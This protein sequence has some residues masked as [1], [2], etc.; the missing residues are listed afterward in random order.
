MV[1]ESTF[2]MGQISP[3]CRPRRLLAALPFGCRAWEVLAI[4]GLLAAERV[5]PAAYWAAAP[6]VLRQCYPDAADRLVRELE[7]TSSAPVVVVA[8][9]VEVRPDEALLPHCWHRSLGVRVMACSQHAPPNFSCVKYL[10]VLL[11]CLSLRWPHKPKLQ[12]VK[13]A[14]SLHAAVEAARQLTADRPD[15]ES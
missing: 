14:A 5:A 8:G 10:K 15:G 1:W 12:R 3:P 4:L 9:A 13:G 6:S 7:G 2:H 11:L